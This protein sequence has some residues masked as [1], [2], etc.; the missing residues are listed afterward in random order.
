MPGVTISNR[1]GTP[2][3]GPLAL[4]LDGLS[5]GVALFDPSGFTAC[6][7][8]SGRPF[9]SI[10]VGA[11]GV[12]SP[13]EIVNVTLEFTNPLNLRISYTPRALAGSNR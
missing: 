7:L 13:G 9:R 11:D 2:I 1:T 4:A 12:L 5:S 8:P 10:S 6:A 3:V